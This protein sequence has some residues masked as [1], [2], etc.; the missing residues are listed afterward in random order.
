MWIFHHPQNS[1]YGFRPDALGSLGILLEVKTRAEGSSGPLNSIEKCPHVSYRRYVQMLNFVFYS[2]IVQKKI[3][4]REL[5]LL[6]Y[7]SWMPHL[8]HKTGDY[9]FA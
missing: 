5:G 8:F 7:R 3:F 2:R 6:Q 9:H 1:K 4:Q